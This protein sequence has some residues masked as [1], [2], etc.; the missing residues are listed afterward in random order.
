MTRRALSNEEMAAD[1][2][3]MNHENIQTAILKVYK[4]VGDLT[5]KDYEAQIKDIKQQR[6]KMFLS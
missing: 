6:S 4:A 3:N 1:M 2:I 5:S